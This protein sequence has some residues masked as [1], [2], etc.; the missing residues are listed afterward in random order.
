VGDYVRE[1][2]SPAQFSSDP[3]SG[4]DAN[5]YGSCNLFKFYFIFNRATAHTREQIFALDCSKDAVWCKKEPFWDN[6][7]VVVRFGGV[8]PPKHP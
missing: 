8:L 1:V 4:R 3:M 6:I 7:C 5:I 2:T